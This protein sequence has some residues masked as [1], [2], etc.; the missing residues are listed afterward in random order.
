[1]ACL[2]ITHKE[3]RKCGQGE[4]EPGAIVFIGVQVRNLSVMGQGEQ[5]GSLKQAGTTFE[6][7][8]R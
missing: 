8:Q 2:E 1:M 7:T 5:L 3:I 4:C 6:T